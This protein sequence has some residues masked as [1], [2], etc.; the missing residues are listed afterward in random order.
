MGVAMPPIF[1]PK[2]TERIKA[3]LKV[4]S[5]LKSLKKV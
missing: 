4:S 3:V 5:F 1:E 2:A